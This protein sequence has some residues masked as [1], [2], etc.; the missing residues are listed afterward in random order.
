MFRKGDRIYLFVE[1][2][3]SVLS[4]LLRPGTNTS[5]SSSSPSSAHLLPQRS[6]CLSV[7]VHSNS[8]GCRGRGRGRGVCQRRLKD[9]VKDG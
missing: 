9:L 4:E 2:V 1:I 8:V 3:Q 6:V 7:H 5:E